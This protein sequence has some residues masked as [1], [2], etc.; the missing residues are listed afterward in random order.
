[1]AGLVEIEQTEQ[2]DATR[3]SENQIRLAVTIFYTLPHNYLYPKGTYSLDRPQWLKFIL[4]HHTD[5]VADVFTQCVRSKLHNG[6]QPVPELYEL[7][8]SDEH[9]EIAR[10]IAL[11]L[12]ESFPDALTDAR[13]YA[14]GWLLKAALLSCEWSQLMKIVKRKLSSGDVDATERVYWLTT[15]FVIAPEKYRE[16][17]KAHVSGE[18]PR[19]RALL[20]FMSSGRFSSVLMQ[21]FNVED[22]ELLISL[23]ASATN[24][25]GVTRNEW[26]IV[27]HLI[28]ELSS[29]PSPDATESLEA[30]SSNANLAIWL[31]AIADTIHRQIGKRREA[32]FQHSDT[33]N[34]VEVLDNRSPANAADLAALM[35]SVIEDLSKQ[36]RD[37]NT[38]D[39]R[40]YWN[41]DPHNRPTEP[42]PE[43]A[44]RDALLSD[45]CDRVKQLGIDAQPEGRY[46]EDKRADIRVSFGNFNVPVEIKKSCHTD[47]WT[48][49]K[50][51]LI[52]KYSRDP[53]AKGYGIYLVFWFGDTE[54]CRPTLGPNLTP[55]NAAE[56]KSGI[57][58]TLTEGEKRKISV[59][60]IDVS[61]PQD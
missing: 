3:L 4:T 15:G 6:K 45:L 46:A 28:E 57:L 55:Q 5:L 12:L 11:P 51:Q 18:K 48:A 22:L 23:M 10:L 32:D 61:K 33:Q 47:L 2:F 14:L 40:Q 21:R 43:D 25:N 9:K 35:V 50:N 20:R 38:S 60:V 52:A 37:G 16:E 13:L 26:W 39:W 59:C 56:L 7:A 41:V 29:V 36:I 19:Q 31:P 44:G 8:T 27:S 24:D 49:I 53:G 1:M 42:K 34:V 30:L 58:D 54:K 17:L